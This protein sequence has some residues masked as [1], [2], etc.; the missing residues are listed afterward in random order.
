[1]DKIPVNFYTNLLNSVRDFFAADFHTLQFYIKKKIYRFEFELPGVT[2]ERLPFRAHNNRIF[3]SE[4]NKKDRNTAQQTDNPFHRNISVLKV[5]KESSTSQLPSEKRSDRKCT[6]E[7]V[8]VRPLFYFRRKKITSYYLMIAYYLFV[9]ISGSR[10]KIKY[11]LRPP[12]LRRSSCGTCSC[13]ADRK[14]K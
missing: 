5:I 2:E 9:I 4:D 6:A 11:H 13:C 7:P 10:Y 8:D 12:E 3:N 1:M 14:K